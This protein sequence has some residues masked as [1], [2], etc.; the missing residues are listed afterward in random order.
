MSHVQFALTLTGVNQTEALNKI[1][2]LTYSH[3][4]KYIL[5]AHDESAQDN[6]H[7]HLYIVLPKRKSVMQVHAL[8]EEISTSIQ[9]LQAVKHKKG[10]IQ[11][12]ANKKQAGHEV[13]CEGDVPAVVKHSIR[14]GGTLKGFN[15]TD[16]DVTC[17]YKLANDM[18]TSRE[19]AIQDFKQR[20]SNA[21]TYKQSAVIAAIN[22]IFPPAPRHIKYTL[23]DFTIPELDFSNNKTKIL[24]G[25]T[26][27]GK[28]Q[29]A[30]AHFKNPLVITNK[31]DWANYNSDVHDGAVIDDMT[32]TKNNPV[33]MLH[34][35]DMREPSSIRVLYGNVTVPA[36]FKRIFTCNSEELFWPENAAAE[37]MEAYRTRCEVIHLLG[38]TKLFGS[39]KC[40][41]KR[42]VPEK[43]TLYETFGIT[44]F[45]DESEEEFQAK[46]LRHNEDNGNSSQESI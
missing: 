42:K 39:E 44:K 16:D 29:F 33:E 11:Y 3:E 26:N 40:T 25:P 13:N 32:F 19:E 20:S 14:N 37:T 24:V 4:I 12:I 34:K 41:I 1:I 31:Q 23:S 30:C 2:E 15:N 17:E 21:W 6:K 7:I 28:T 10:Y 45:S 5:Y 38:G 8:L 46:K 9:Y 18:Y 43:S 22:R 35:L 27:I 36:G